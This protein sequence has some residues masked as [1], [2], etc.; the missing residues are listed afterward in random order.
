MT[1]VF[2]G[3]SM[4]DSFPFLVL[5]ETCDAAVNWAAEQIQHAAMKVIRTFDLQAARHD[6]TD[7]TCPHHG[8]QECDC[9][10][11]VLLVYP[12]ADQNLTDCQPLSLV[13]HS[14]ARRTWFSVVDTPQQRADPKL[15][16][17]VRRALAVNLPKSGNNLLAE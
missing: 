2:S 7:C 3:A 11:I 9:Q 16:A 1:G 15:S 6:Q 5:G 14:H 12:A 17:A 8:S 10:M 4:S 13:A